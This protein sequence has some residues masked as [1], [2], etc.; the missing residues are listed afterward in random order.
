MAQQNI[1]D[2]QPP[3]HTLTELNNLSNLANQTF[4]F[5]S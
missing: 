3:Q 1:F 4:K 5:Q 2:L